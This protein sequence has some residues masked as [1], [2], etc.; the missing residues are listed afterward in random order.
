MQ[1]YSIRHRL[2]RK[3]A[4]GFSRERNCG[5]VAWH[6]R[7]QATR[8]FLALLRSCHSLAFSVLM[9]YN[10]PVES[11]SVVVVRRWLRPLSLLPGRFPP[12]RKND[13]RT[14][15]PGSAWWVVTPP[16]R[17]SYFSRPFLVGRKTRSTRESSG[18]SCPLLYHVSSCVLCRKSE[19]QA[20]RFIGEYD[21]ARLL[22]DQK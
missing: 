20:P 12:P 1:R 11:Q 16:A 21:D 13:R 17:N 19:A 22:I 5:R 15:I 10:G 3:V 4:S 7:T 8:C 18:Q 2:N 6:I 14:N 9:R